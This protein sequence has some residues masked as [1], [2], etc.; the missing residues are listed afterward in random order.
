MSGILGF[1][2]DR[3]R[4][5]DIDRLHRALRSLEQ[6]GRDDRSSLLLNTLSGLSFFHV[7]A[8]ESTPWSPVPL[9]SFMNGMADAML[10]GSC[11]LYENPAPHPPNS[12]AA[13]D[14]RVVIAF[15]GVIDNLAELRG[16]LLRLGENVPSDEPL[17]ILRTAFEK[18]GPEALAQIHGSFAIAVMDVYKGRLILARDAFGTRPLYYSHPNDTEIF[19]GSQIA[20]V[21]ELSSGVRRVNRASLFRY[22][23]RNSMDHAPETFFEGIWQ[24]L[25]G[26]YLEA[27]LRKPSDCFVRSYRTA[28]PTESNVSFGEAALG[29]RELV[30]QSVA[31]QVGFQNSIGAA[32]SGGFDSSFV[33][34]AFERAC[35]EAQLQ[36]Y[37]C[38][39]LVKDGDFSQSEEAWAD[40]AA[41]GFRSPVH[42][43]YVSAQDLPQQLDSV[44]LLQEE[45]FSSPV[46]FAQWQLF[47]AAKDHGVRMMLSGQGGD[48]MFASSSRQVLHA[49]FAHLRRGSWRGAAALLEAASR[50]PHGGIRQLAR[51]AGQSVLPR[52]LQPFVRRFVRPP[53]P[54]W[55]K[56]DWFEFAVAPS[57]S[58]YG[59]PMLR[60]EDRNS[61]ACGILNRMPLL[62]TGIQD[63]V[64]S[65]PPE[66]FVKAEQ[67]L[68]SIEWAALRGLVPDAILARKQRSGFPVPV[69]EWLCE[70]APWVDTAMDEVS[71]LPFLEPSQAG[72]IW[73]SV[74]SQ[75]GSI[76]NGFLVWRWILLYSWLRNLNVRLD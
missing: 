38:V 21:V 68:K 73:E 7:A 63:F 64:Q 1:A 55:L 28:V 66:Y 67:P 74:R 22:L 6:R 25:P 34:A 20:A 19:F 18:W 65:L 10:S 12:L 31:S 13:P 48:T 59:L 43:V 36:L 61:T 56:A 45:P 23:V 9:E 39:P 3:P 40:L 5:M 54:G 37:T 53:I 24:I 14:S 17:V 16:D 71:N 35:P 47:R 72:Q 44:V 69:R 32:H 42:K 75:N 50:L 51:A 58:G 27:S 33:I 11:L 70:L 76:Q 46:V 4:A 57:V 2:A 41:S 30:V 29:L 15:D 62:A 8:S 49:I 26:H 52:G 60:F